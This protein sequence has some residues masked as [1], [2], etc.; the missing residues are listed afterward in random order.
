MKTKRDLWVSDLFRFFTESGNVSIFFE[1][2][3]RLNDNGK[4]INLSIHPVR[5]ADD[6]FFN[7]ETNDNEL[8]KKLRKYE[9]NYDLF[10]FHAELLKENLRRK[11]KKS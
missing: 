8:E 10:Y 1:Q 11:N 6:I 7:F 4:I 3:E 2:K 5:F 9:V